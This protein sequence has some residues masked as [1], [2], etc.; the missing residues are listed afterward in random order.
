MP[1]QQAVTCAT[2]RWWCPNRCHARCAGLA[3]AARRPSGLVR[4]AT[5]FDVYKPKAARGRHGAGERSLA[6]AWNCWT[7]TPR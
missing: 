3:A 7:T 5:L 2:W 4:A 6:C 1:R